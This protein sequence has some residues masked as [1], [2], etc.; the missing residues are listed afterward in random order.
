MAYVVTRPGCHTD[1]DELL[2]L[3]RRELASFKVPVAVNFVVEL[4]Y[5]AVG[6]VLRRE[7]RQ[8]QRRPHSEEGAL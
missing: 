4:P 7:L 3:C 8:I 1:A 6:K 5:S 2:E